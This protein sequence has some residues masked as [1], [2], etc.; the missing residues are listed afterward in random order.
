MAIADAMCRDLDEGEQLRVC[1]AVDGERFV[2]VHIAG[3]TPEDDYREVSGV[4]S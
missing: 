1:V 3:G 4:L 2:I